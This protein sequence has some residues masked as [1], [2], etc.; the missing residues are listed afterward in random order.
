MPIA[1][2]SMLAA[3]SDYVS[4]W[5]IALVPILVGLIWFYFWNKKRQM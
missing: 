4:W 1:F 2:A 5:Q 3:V